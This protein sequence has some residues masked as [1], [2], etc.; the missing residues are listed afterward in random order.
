[1]KMVLKNFLDV[2]ICSLNQLMKITLFVC[3]VHLYQMM[4]LN[5]LLALSKIKLTQITMIVLIQV[6]CLNLI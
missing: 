5:V 3:K 4:M 2:V 6:K 1:M